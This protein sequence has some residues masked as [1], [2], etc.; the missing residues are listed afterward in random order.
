MNASR[1]ACAAVAVILATS[2]KSPAANPAVPDFNELRTVIREHLVGVTDAEL[3]RSSVEGLL[4]SLRGKVRLL[5]ETKASGVTSNAPALAQSTVIEGAAYLRIHEI[6]ASL[7]TA[8]A[9]SC[10]ALA[11]SN[12]LT[13]VILDLRFADG[14]DYAAAAAVADQFVTKAT[15]LLDW[16]AGVV[17]AT[18]KTNALSGPIAVLVNTETTGA[19]EAL[20]ATLRECGVGLLLGNVT[21]GAAMTAEEF[22]LKNGSRVKIATGPV[23]VG[24]G[25][26]LSEQGVKP[27]IE[28]AVRPEAEREF[29]Q[30]PYTTASPPRTNSLATSATSTNR[31]AR[32]PRINEAD[33]VRA[34]RDGVPLDAELLSLR[35][36]EPERP[37]LRD[38]TLAR[39]VD[40]LKGLA[41]V[42]RT[43]P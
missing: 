19:A 30:N 17:S 5:A 35:E 31:P 29:L 9:S 21:R 36:P 25:K 2:G 18:A 27:D 42:R 38:P 15:P 26:P 3:N 10:R 23:K 13:G 24:E 12:S 20:A 22:M 40:L 39:A 7:P 4:H 6:D 41:V 43:R 32:R 11:A 14:D 16:G 33:L 28:V 34:R 8:V 37:S 1:I